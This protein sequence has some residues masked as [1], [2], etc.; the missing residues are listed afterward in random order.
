MRRNRNGLA[1]GISIAGAVL[2]VT[3]LLRYYWSDHPFHPVPVTAA[4]ILLFVGGALWNF[5]RTT[6]IAGVVVGHAVTIISALP[7]VFTRRTTDRITA[8]GGTVVLTPTAEHE[9]P[10]AVTPTPAPAPPG[11]DQGEQ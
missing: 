9:V 3:E 2:F 11:L 1:I 10:V 7:G 4:T 8:S 5:E 6:A